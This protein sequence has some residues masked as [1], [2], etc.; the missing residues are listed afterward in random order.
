MYCGVDASSLSWSKSICNP[1]MGITRIRQLPP[2]KGEHLELAQTSWAVGLSPDS[3]AAGFSWG[4]LIYSVHSNAVTCMNYGGLILYVIP[5]WASQ[6]LLG[7]YRSL[8]QGHGGWLKISISAGYLHYDWIYHNNSVHW[9]SSSRKVMHPSNIPPLGALNLN[10]PMGSW[11]RPWV[12]GLSHPLVAILTFTWYMALDHHQL[13]LC[14]IY[15]LLL[16]VFVKLQ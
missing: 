16:S 3:Q 1:E 2:F 13:R 14:I 12:Q 15:I 6:E 5:E 7:V 11:P 9:K 4:W 10:V 8:P